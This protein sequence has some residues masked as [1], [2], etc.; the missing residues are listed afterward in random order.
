MDDP[1]VAF[2]LTHE[3]QGPGQ[4]GLQ[5]EGKLTGQQLPQGCSDETRDLRAADRLQPTTLGRV[6]CEAGLDVREISGAGPRV[7]G[8]GADGTLA[9]TRRGEWPANGTISGTS[10][11]CSRA[12]IAAMSAAAREISGRSRE[13]LF[14]TRSG[15]SARTSSTVSA[16]SSR[17]A[18]LKTVSS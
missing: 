6:D 1:R 5:V 15:F 4:H 10:P 2:Q 8:K 11:F 7:S 12:S 13:S 18:P 14:V 17:F 9:G 16:S 3:P